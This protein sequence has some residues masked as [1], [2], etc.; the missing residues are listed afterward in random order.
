MNADLIFSPH[1]LLVLYACIAMLLFCLFNFLFSINLTRPVVIFLGFCFIG[2]GVFGHITF[3]DMLELCRKLEASGKVSLDVLLRFERYHL[4]FA[5]MFPF[6][7]G[8]IGTNVISDALLKHHT[9]ERSFS[10]FQFLKDILQCVL[11]PIG[12]V[13]GIV[14][15]IFWFIYFSISSIR[16]LLHSKIPRTRRWMYMKTLKFSIISRNYFHSLRSSLKKT[17]FDDTY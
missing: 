11:M 2:V 6:I 10:L 13:L 16:R 4:V 15:C 7:S 3:L 17:G 12:F 1:I 9:Y 8:A 5:Y 14:I